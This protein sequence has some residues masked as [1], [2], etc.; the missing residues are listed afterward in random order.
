MVVH[1]LLFRWPLQTE[2]HAHPTTSESVVA[3][4]ISVKLNQKSYGLTVKF[5]VET[6][7]TLFLAQRRHDHA[8]P[9]RVQ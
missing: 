7:T 2:A 9:L 5:G 8:G 4:L 6:F 3:D 1:A